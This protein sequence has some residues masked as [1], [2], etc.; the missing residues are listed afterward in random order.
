[1]GQKA[2]NFI[3]AV[4][5]TL[6]AVKTYLV[7]REEGF[8][9]ADSFGMIHYV[10]LGWKEWWWEWLP[11]L[12]SGQWGWLLTSGWLRKRLWCK[13]QSPLPSCPLSLP[14]PY[15]LKV[16]H[17]PQTVHHLGT[18]FQKH[19]PVGD[20]LHLSIATMMYLLSP[21]ALEIKFY[22]ESWQERQHRHSEFIFFREKKR[23]EGRKTGPWSQWGEM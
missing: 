1:M 17:D 21:S 6:T 10:H 5:P 14:R 3:A 4:V 9:L 22:G 20:I 11:T 8:I 23:Y 16:P 12:V 7:G 18:S 2:C 13:A 19:E 15:I